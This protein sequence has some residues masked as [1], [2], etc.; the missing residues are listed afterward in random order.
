MNTA[1]SH[2]GCIIRSLRPIRG[3]SLFVAS[4]AIAWR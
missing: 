4:F 2:I 1:F 3:H